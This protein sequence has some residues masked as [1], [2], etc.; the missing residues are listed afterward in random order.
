LGKPIVAIVGRQNV[1]KSTLMNRLAGRR[2]AIVEDY[3]GTT[4]DRVIAEVTWNGVVFDLVDTGGLEIRADTTL[5]QAVKG[6]AETAIADA[7]VIVFVVDVHDGVVPIDLEIADVLRR[8]SK[9][10]V[11]VANKADRNQH[12]GAAVDF[13]EFSLGEPIP[14]SGHHG[15]GAA[16][17]LDAIVEVLPTAVEAPAEANPETQKIAIVGR[18]NV[19]KSMLVNRLLGM[20]RSIVSEIPGTTRDA[21]DT[22]L[23][24]RDHELV[25]IDTAGIRRRGK[26]TGVE[27][28]SVMRSM[29]AI[30]RCDVAV[31]VLDATDPTTAQDLHVAGMIQTA[32]KGVVIVVNKWDLVADSTPDEYTMYIMNE[33]KFMPYAAVLYT[34]ALSGKGVKKILPEAVR[35]HEQRQIRLPTAAVNSVVQQAVGSHSLIRRGKRL[36]VLY[37]TQAE[38]DPPTFIFFV[39]DARLVHFSYQRFLENKL[40]EAFGFIGTPLRLIFKSRGEHD[41]G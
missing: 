10:V 16:E 9:P 24:Y 5:A 14:V 11:L 32:L 19:G 12:V 40:R 2:L 13:W 25:L 23:K 37:A 34:S 3:A 33:L 35:V 6:Q 26:Q 28:Y 18:P 8:T 1:G 29:R 17:L 39:N 36:N 30:E 27:R 7:D 15:R 4:R 21:I 31:L 20:D 41:R 38:T 22:N